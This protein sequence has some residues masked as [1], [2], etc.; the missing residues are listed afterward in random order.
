MEV[1]VAP[2]IEEAP[3]RCKRQDPRNRRQVRMAEAQRARYMVSSPRPHRWRPGARLH[4]R[5]RNSTAEGGRQQPRTRCCFLRGGNAQ[6]RA[7]RHQRHDPVAENP[8]I[9]RHHPWKKLMN[10]G[11]RV[12]NTLIKGLG[13]VELFSGTARNINSAADRDRHQARDDSRPADDRR[14]Q[15]HSC[16][17]PC[18]SSE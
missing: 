9:I 17:C 8:P 14:T 5:T 7:S 15:V 12:T 2:R 10:Q 1:V 6:V 4:R 13:L 3:A 11:V 18:V 16:R